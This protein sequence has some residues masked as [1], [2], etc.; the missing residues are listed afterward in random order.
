MTF[1]KTRKEHPLGK[2]IALTYKKQGGLDRA[3]KYNA[4]TRQE[5]DNH[6]PLIS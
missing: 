5:G 4:V 2:N 3:I 1:I 6:C